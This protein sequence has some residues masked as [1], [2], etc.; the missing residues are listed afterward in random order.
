MITKIKDY[1]FSLREEGLF[2]YVALGFICTALMEGNALLS[3]QL[4]QNIFF[5]TIIG[6]M[7]INIIMFLLGV[8]IVLS[9]LNTL[10]SNAK[11][12][13][14]T[15][16]ALDELHK[17]IK[18]LCYIASFSSAGIAIFCALLYVIS[19]FIGKES[20]YGKYAINFAVIFAFFILIRILL[21]WLTQRFLVPM[22][23]DTY[24]KIFAS[25]VILIVIGIPYFY[26]STE[27]VSIVIDKKKYQEIKQKTNMKPE[28]FI[29]NKINE[30]KFE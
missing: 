11:V 18:Q 19:L 24:G 28:D 16:R 17:R 9:L 7:P 3:Y 29:N 4:Q 23:K 21:S 1:I 6:F 22:A 25:L 2:F 12:N 8:E 27:T 13:A 30:F 26:N 10:I 20:N 15:K 5:D 14:L